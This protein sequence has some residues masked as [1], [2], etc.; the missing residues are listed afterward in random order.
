MTIVLPIP[1]GTSPTPTPQPVPDE[2]NWGDNSDVCSVLAPTQITDDLIESITAGGIELPED[3][4]PAWDSAATYG[5]GDQVYLGHRVYESVQAGNTNKDPSLIANQ[6]NAAG[7]ATWW[8]D[9]G[10]T[11]RYAM[12]DALISTQTAA[13]TPLV[14]TLNPG[15]FNGLALFGIDADYLD[16]QITD[17]YQ[18]PTIY[19]YSAPLEGSMPADYYEYFFERFKPQTQFIAT[20]FDPYASARITVTLTKGSGQAKLGMLALGDLRPL[21]EPLRGASVEPVDYSYVSTDAFGNTTIRR[22]SNA[23]GLSIQA[24]MSIDDANTVLATV[25]ELLGVPVVVVGSTAPG[26]E[27]LTVFGLLSA[28]LQY[29]DYGSPTLNATVKGLI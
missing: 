17:G 21:G 27:A 23:T 20:G 25:K 22:R 6:V 12:F 8:F 5:V 2:G 13:D 11:N 15:A 29:D 26:Y 3:P 24:K 19:S 1:G 4:N 9:V 16:I 18:G 14:I 10:P 7:V 28:R